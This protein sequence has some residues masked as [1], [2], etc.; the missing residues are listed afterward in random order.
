MPSPAAD[1]PLR[2]A[3][4]VKQIPKFEE[5]R[6][7]VDG[8]LV[9]HGV[10]LHMNDYCRRG[11]R[12][13]CDLAEATGG[14]CTAITLGPPEA[15]TVLREAILCGCVGGLH[16]SDPVFAGSDTLSTARALAAALVA[17]GPWDLVLCGRNSVDAD[18]GQV[19]AQVAELLGLPLLTGVRELELDGETVRVLLEHDDEW[20]RCEVELPAVLSCAE[21][22]CDP[23]KVKEPDAWAT[24]DAD[25]LTTVPAADLGTGPWGQAGSATAV[26]DIRVLAVERVGERLEGAG[27]GQ[28]ERVA[29]V[30]RLR[31][32]L[33]PAGL[34]S[35]SVAEPCPEAPEIVVLVEPDRE[36]VTAELLAAAAVLGG[37]V[38]A[39]G[40]DLRAELST[41]GADRLLSVTGDCGEDDLAAA[42]ADHL[43]D[44]LPWAVLAPGTA[45]GRHVAA[46][47]AARLGAGLTGDAVGLERRGDRLVALKPA[48][49][50]RLVAEITCTSQTQMA[51]V[52]PGV[53]P[54][55]G[56]RE[57]RS[58][59]LQHLQVPAH[60]RV[61]VHERWRDDDADLLANAEVVIGVGQGV[62]PGDLDLVRRYADSLGAE[63]CA[64]RKVTDAGWMPRARQVGITGHS[65]APR[66]YVAI[67]TSGRFNHMVGV[68]RAG[69]IVGINPDPDCDLWAECDIGLVADWHEAL[70]ALVERL[71][72]P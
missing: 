61:R 68:R 59:D 22:L 43:A 39:M 48:F 67:G 52:R 49:G 42:I 72:G 60:S 29:E 36:R 71:A 21:R 6:L 30:L 26:G 27:A 15:H 20:V 31:G 25:L 46:R 32:A 5:M 50:G 16:V 37:N 8:R 56:P 57:P 41:R 3:A 66:L 54:L 9:R 58:I 35:D 13:G 11:I 23:C 40:V 4:L 51:T 63:L 53:L 55:P 17:N 38:T 34:R 14:T 47:L 2:I 69:T 65:I 1:R 70:P 64:T 19:P 10:E 62:E 28:V 24:V 45:W 33:A 7:G 12:Q 44:D 18:T